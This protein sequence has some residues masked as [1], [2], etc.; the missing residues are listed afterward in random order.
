MRIIAG[1]PVQHPQFP[2]RTVDATQVTTTVQPQ[3]TR[4]QQEAARLTSS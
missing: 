1:D 4:Q 2:G 3:A